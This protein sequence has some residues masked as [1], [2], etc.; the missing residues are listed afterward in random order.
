MRLGNRA[1]SSALG[2][3]NLWKL[4]ATQVANTRQTHQKKQYPKVKTKSKR[5]KNKRF[6][7]LWR[8]AKTLKEKVYIRLNFNGIQHDRQKIPLG[9]L[10]RS[11]GPARAGKGA[12][13]LGQHHLYN[14]H[15]S[16]LRGERLG[17]DREFCGKQE[18]GIL[19]IPKL[20]DMLDVEGSVI[21][22]AKRNCRYAGKCWRRF[23][24]KNTCRI[25]C[26]E[27]SHCFFVVSQHQT[28]TARRYLSTCC[29]FWCVCRG[30]MSAIVKSIRNI[31]YLCGLKKNEHDWIRENAQQPA[32]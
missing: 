26:K 6:K 31:L 22:T 32:V 18:N 10:F 7:S 24:T 3:R 29:K 27:R 20:L 21:T 11:R 30:R 8:G 2:F 17:R 19:A 9:T 15:G 13:H 25:C 12:S 28:Q 23:L 1:S 16:P 4:F 14:H 5:T